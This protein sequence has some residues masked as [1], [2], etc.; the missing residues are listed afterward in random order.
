MRTTLRPRRLVPLLATSAAVAVLGIAG[1]VHMR[2]DRSW[3][4]MQVIAEGLQQR[5]QSRPHHRQPLWGE[6][7]PGSAFAHYEQAMQKA[8][9]LGVADKDALLAMLPRTDADT[10]EATESQALLARW[11]PVLAALHEGAHAVDAT[12]PPAPT[13]PG[14]PGMTNLLDA[15]WVANLAMFDARAL[16]ARGDG[17]AAVQRSLDAATFGVD[18]NR[19][20]TLIEQMVASALVA[21]AVNECWPEAALQH[22][23]PNALSALADGLEKLDAALPET[24]DFDGEMSFSLRWSMATPAESMPS[25]FAAWRYGFSTRWMFADAMLRT[26]GTHQEL[27]AATKLAWPQREALFELELGALAACGN[28]IVAMMVPNLASAERGLRETKTL[29]QLLR[30]SVAFHRGLD[31]P[32]LRDP[33]GDGPLRVTRQA[34]SSVRLHG[35]GTEWRKNLERTVTP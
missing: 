26:A 3:Q 29:V 33:L 32:P 18:L 15:R 4:A 11:Q 17:L 20:G 14:Q 10:A 28:P 7:K 22:L 6:G 2:A 25:T 8:R 23:D 12:P 27:G 31:L 34:D 24:V 21:I 5:L 35:A 13:M 9:E 1:V 16:R 19:K 30:M